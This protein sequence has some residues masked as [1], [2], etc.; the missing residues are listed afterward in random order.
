MKKIDFKKHICIII[1]ILVISVLIE[2]LLMI[3]NI[4]IKYIFSKKK[5]INNEPVVIEIK[6]LEI[7]EE[8]KNIYLTYNSNEQIN[9]KNIKLMLKE[10]NEDVYIRFIYDEDE[11]KMEKSNKEQTSFKAYLPEEISINQFKIVFPSNQINIDNIEKIIVNSNIDYLPEKIFSIY[12]VCIIFITLLIIY[13]A[14]NIYKK[15]KGINIKKE[16]IFLILGICLGLGLVIINVPLSKYD[17]H[18]HFWR[19]YELANGVIKSGTQELPNSIFDIVID[20]EGVYH[21][22]K[23]TSYNYMKK[24][25]N[26]DLDKTDKSM[27]TVGA[28]ATLSPFSYIPQTLGCTI[29]NILNLKPILIVY[30]ARL[31]NLLFYIGIIYIAIKI[32]PKEKWK[33]I[34][35][36]IAL[37][38]MSLNLAASI[39]P[40]ATIISLSILIVSYILNLK[41]KKE[42]VNIKNCVI[43]VTLNLIVSMCKIVYLP[44]MLLYFLIPAEKFKNKRQ[45]NLL[46]LTNILLFISVYFIWQNIATGA[47]TIIRTSTT[48]QIYFTLSNIIRDVY[49]GIN[50]VYKF[51][52]DYYLTMIGGWNTQPIITIIFSIIL[53]ITIFGKNKDEIFEKDEIELE[54]KDKILISIAVS[55]SFLLIFVGLYIPWTRACFTY[56]EGV[57]GRYFLPVLPLLILSFE[58]NKFYYNI[59]NRNSRLMYLIVLLYIQ[60]YIYTI[61]SYI[62]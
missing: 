49:T 44:I 22:E 59:E 14:I 20:D 39:S 19:A 35:M 27:Q 51:S 8:E 62:K 48:E 28:T 61:T 34:I 12:E 6:D 31:S 46:F 60:I 16:K 42:K 24:M 4:G 55:I 41:F 53:F 18:A 15:L 21:I 33:E 25:S 26:M 11:K 58:K 3:Y 40:D 47:V 56:V 45:R 23:R 13:I 2:C 38:P 30:L 52:T 57:Q 32:T 50:T 1:A 54:R 37:F 29:G 10:E 9:I 5:L 43:L 17:E 36:L 7:K